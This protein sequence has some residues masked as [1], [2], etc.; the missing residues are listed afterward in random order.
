MNRQALALELANVYAEMARRERTVL[1][2][3]VDELSRYVQP[4]PSSAK[5]YVLL[6]LGDKVV[7]LRVP[8][9]DGDTMRPKTRFKGWLARKRNWP[10]DMGRA[11]SWASELDEL[12]TLGTSD[13]AQPV[14]RPVS[15]S[16]R[17]PVV[18]TERASPDI[19][20]PPP[21]F[22]RKCRVTLSDELLAL[23][24]AG[25]RITKI[26]VPPYQPPSADKK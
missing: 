2:A 8:R 25:G 13:A 5:I 4:N 19:K 3:I 24:K 21:R 26:T 16:L 23:L 9:T 15:A 1:Q 6:W 10:D 18:G 22:Y 11:R 14:L 17:E 20:P 12:N 7:T